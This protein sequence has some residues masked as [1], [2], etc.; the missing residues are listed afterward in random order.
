MPSDNPIYFIV[1][2]PITEE[3]I[4]ESERDGTRDGSRDTGGGWG[5]EPR[6]SRVDAIN[7]FRERVVTR[8][9]I[10]VDSGKLKSQLQDLSR[11]SMSYLM[12]I[13]RTR[14]PSLHPDYSSKKLPCRCRSM[15]RAN[16]ASLAQAAKSAA[17][18][19]LL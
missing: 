1:E 13:S 8:Q 9:R 11:R 3:V 7:Q 6:R 4:T 16:S 2:E 14:L 5:T 10:G 17:P 12:S 19:A 18:V 15:L